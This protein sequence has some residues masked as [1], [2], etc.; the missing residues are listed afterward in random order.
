MWTSGKK[1]GVVIYKK[2]ASPRFGVQTMKYSKLRKRR[3]EVGP[4]EPARI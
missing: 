2:T 3:R 4:W 1:V